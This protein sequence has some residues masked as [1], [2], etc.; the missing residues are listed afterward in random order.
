LRKGGKCRKKKRE[1][2]KELKET[3]RE[4]ERREG[5]GGRRRKTDLQ[6]SKEGNCQTKIER[7]NR[8]NLLLVKGLKRLT[9]TD[10]T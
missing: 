1:G 8:N 6:R 9:W 7:E 5:D 10:L 3:E 2:R 4:R